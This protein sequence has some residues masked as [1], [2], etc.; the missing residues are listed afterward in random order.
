MAA[1][2]W[3]PISV[4]C[5]VI[6]HS[7]PHYGAINPG[8]TP[9]L[10]YCLVLFWKFR[11]LRPGLLPLTTAYKTWQRCVLSWDHQII[12][13]VSDWLL[14]CPVSLLLTAQESLQNSSDLSL[15]VKCPRQYFTGHYQHTSDFSIPNTFLLRDSGSVY[16]SVS[17][18][19][20]SCLSFQRA[21]CLTMTRVE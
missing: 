4:S 2:L 21:Q 9:L 19:S 10:E 3:D 6:T 8:M 13:I 5:H 14:Q 15:Y 7:R 20:V 16:F 18:E 17:E 11:V 1:E 12:A